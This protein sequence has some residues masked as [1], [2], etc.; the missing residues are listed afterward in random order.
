MKTATGG[1]DFD[2]HGDEVLERIRRASRLGINKTMTECVIIAKHSH[3]FVN[4]TGTAERSIRIVMAAKTLAGHT[5]GIWGSMQVAYFWY[6]EFGTKIM[7]KSYA[8][9]RPTAAKVY[10]RLAENIRAGWRMG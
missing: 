3:P 5:M 8:T 10:P 1:D 7:K 9:L 2:W 6:L 4:R